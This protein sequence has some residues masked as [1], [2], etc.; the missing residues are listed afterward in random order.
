MQKGRVRAYPAVKD[1]HSYSKIVHRKDTKMSQMSL[2]RRLLV[3]H[4]WQRRCAS[5]HKAS[6]TAVRS[7]SWNLYQIGE[8]R[9]PRVRDLPLTSQIDPALGPQQK[10]GCKRSEWNSRAIPRG[11]KDRG[12][13]RNETSMD[14]ISTTGGRR[15]SRRDERIDNLR[16]QC[17]RAVT[18]PKSH[19][20][21]RK[22]RDTTDADADHG[23]TISPH[24]FYTH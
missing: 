4:C 20:K 2:E 3:T 24:V 10:V 16:K 5:L 14:A 13:W 9:M 12:C 8:S 6:C 19:Q 23:L 22:R 7:V 17:T 11:K 18:R 15:S 1:T 21:K